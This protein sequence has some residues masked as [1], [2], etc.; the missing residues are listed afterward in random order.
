MTL[1]TYEKMMEAYNALFAFEKE[2]TF[3]EKEAL[4]ELLRKWFTH[5]A[6]ETE[7]LCLE[8]LRREA[9]EKI[10]GALAALLTYDGQL[11]TLRNFELE[12]Y[13]KAWLSHSMEIDVIKK[14]YGK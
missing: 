3:S 2:D 4:L 8:G 9:A 6:A 13:M 5:Y 7:S 10:Q 11:P 14:E 12:T 1:E